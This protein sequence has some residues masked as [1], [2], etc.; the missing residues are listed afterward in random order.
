MNQQ[1]TLDAMRNLRLT[2]MADRYPDHAGLG[3]LRA[4]VLRHHCQAH[5]VAYLRCQLVFR[6]LHHRRCATAPG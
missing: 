1:S 3:F 2:G 6:R 5:G 4:G